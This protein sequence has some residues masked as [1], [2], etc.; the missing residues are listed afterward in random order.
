MDLYAIATFDC[1]FIAVI[2]LTI[3]LKPLRHVE[4]PIIHLDVTLKLAS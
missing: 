1:A 3:R 4:M 2:Y